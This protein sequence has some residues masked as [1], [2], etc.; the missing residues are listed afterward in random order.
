[1][2]VRMFFHSKS[3]ETMDK[4]SPIEARTDQNLGFSIRFGRYHRLREQQK[5]SFLY[6]ESLERWTQ[7]FQRARRVSSRITSVVL[8][9]STKKWIERRPGVLGPLLSVCL[10]IHGG[11]WSGTKILFAACLGRFLEP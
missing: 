11:S 7:V 2:S 9:A 4:Q 8:L 1:M 6:Y 5:T 3:P 10:N